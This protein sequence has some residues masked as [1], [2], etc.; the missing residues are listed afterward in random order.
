V[1]EEGDEEDEEEDLDND[2]HKKTD[3]TAAAG[4][5]IEFSDDDEES[6][7]EESGDMAVAEFLPETLAALPKSPASAHKRRKQDT[8]AIK[9]AP[10]FG[11][12]CQSVFKVKSSN[13]RDKLK[14]SLQ[15]KSCM[16]SSA[17]TAKKFGLA[18][19]DDLVKVLG[20]IE[21][22]RSVPFDN[23]PLSCD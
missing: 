15:Q 6:C 1:E 20:G 18:S 11:G 7:D 4:E 8:A 16:Q 22:E 12:H 2:D 21:L 9:N 14:N 13:A 23:N 17:V 10:L 19:K 5:F 3:E